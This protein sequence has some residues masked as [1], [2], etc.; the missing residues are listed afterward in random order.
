[1]KKPKQTNSTSS[2][3]FYLNCMLAIAVILIGVVYQFFVKPDGE[4]EEVESGV[5]R[6]TEGVFDEIPPYPLFT[7]DDLAQY[8][9]ESESHVIVLI[10][11][12][13]YMSTNPSLIVEKPQL[14]LA[15]MGD[16]FDVSRGAKV[17]IRIISHPHIYYRPF[18]NVRLW[19]TLCSIMEKISRTTHS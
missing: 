13:C 16:I 19:H 9:G 18:D 5:G 6:K 12:N 10:G 8:D 4:L 1:M 15:I 11:N 7:A 2:P 3:V 17:R 14:Y